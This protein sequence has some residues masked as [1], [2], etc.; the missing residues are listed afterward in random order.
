[1]TWRARHSCPW[2]PHILDVRRSAGEMVTGCY[3]LMMCMDNDASVTPEAL[4]KL[5][6]NVQ[7]VVAGA[8][9]R[10]HFSSN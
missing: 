10:S 8:Y 3:S 5:S 6:E 7:G 4:E 9:T 1:M 2:E